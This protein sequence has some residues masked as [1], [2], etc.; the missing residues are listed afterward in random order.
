MSPAVDRRLPEDEREAWAT[1]SGRLSGSSLSKVVYI[2]SSIGRAFRDLQ[3][4]V[5]SLLG[6][7]LPCHEDTVVCDFIAN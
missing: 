1:Q 2:G 4:T 5:F 3:N 6:F 7:P